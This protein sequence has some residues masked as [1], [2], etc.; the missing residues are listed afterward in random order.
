[1]ATVKKNID[2]EKRKRLEE[3]QKRHDRW[4]LK[5]VTLDRGG[6]E[7]NRGDFDHRSTPPSPDTQENW[8]RVND[9]PDQGSRGGRG[10]WEQV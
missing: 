7:R 1:M 6:K 4:W 8:K 5:K 3:A 9:A 10:Q 2:P